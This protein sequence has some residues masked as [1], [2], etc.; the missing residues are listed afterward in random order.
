MKLWGGRFSKP[1]S[2]LLDEFNASIEFDKRLFRQDIR[3]SKAHARM[4]GKIGILTTKEVLQLVEGLEGILRDMEAGTVPYTKADE[5]IHMWVERVLTERIGTV[6]KKL[7]TGRS[8][9]DQVAVDLKLYMK[10]ELAEIA[11][12]LLELLETLVSMADMHKDTVLPGMTHLQNAQPVTFGYHLMAYFQMFKRDYSRLLDCIERMDL[13]PLGSG[14]L[15]GVTYASDRSYTALELG[16]AGVTENAMDSVSDRD[17][18]IEFI[19]DASILMMHLSRFCEELILWNSSPFS[20]IEMDDAFSTGSSIMPQKKNPDVAELIRGKTGRTY[21]NLI[22]ILTLMKSLPL[23]YDK[24][25]QEDK[26]P[27]FDTV[28][29]LKPCLKIFI[30][31]IETMTVKQENMLKAA[32]LGYTNAT[33]VADYLVRKGLPFRSAYEVSGQMV[34]SC[35]LKGILIEEQSLE[36]FKVFSSLFEMDVLD[37]VQL[38]SCME[39]KKSYG[40]TAQSSI[41]TMI[42]NGRIFLKTENG[43]FVKP[44]ATILL[45]KPDKA[46]PS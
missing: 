10:D 35:I 22:N 30:E 37:A 8:R 5:D 46:F 29:T 24:D 17:H 36:E 34:R 18:V 7:H 28:D 20:F 3:G 45:P 2:E 23:A 40:S 32:S 38:K 31:M 21:G 27:L 1:A 16:F 26:P 19:A 39:A 43:R 6:G 33:D 25:M 15:A 4:L 44:S 9:N 13:S 42:E 12:L 14:A 11:G 41:L